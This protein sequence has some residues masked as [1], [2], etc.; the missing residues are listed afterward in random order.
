MTV[1]L[2]SVAFIYSTD[3]KLVL[4]HERPENCQ[5]DNG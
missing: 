4:W 2:E 1:E 3:L 5:Y